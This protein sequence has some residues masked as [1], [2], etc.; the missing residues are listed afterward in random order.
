MFCYSSTN[1]Q[2]LKVWQTFG[3]TIKYNWVAAL[4]YFPLSL[5]AILLLSLLHYVIS[6]LC[7]W[8]WR[9]CWCCL[10]AIFHKMV[11]RRECLIQY[12]SCNGMDSY[13][14]SSGNLDLVFVKHQTFYSTLLAHVLLGNIT[15]LLNLLDSGNNKISCW[16]IRGQHRAASQTIPTY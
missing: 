1:G 6:F 10:K 13:A 9:L 2:I 11:A 4:C 5:S 8:K 15:F 14:W 12:G 16:K 3:S 7:V